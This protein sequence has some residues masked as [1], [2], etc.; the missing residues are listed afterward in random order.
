M[1]LAINVDISGFKGET[2]PVLAESEQRLL[3]DIEVQ[4]TTTEARDTES[5]A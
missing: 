2:E 1:G 5:G 4:S 3:S